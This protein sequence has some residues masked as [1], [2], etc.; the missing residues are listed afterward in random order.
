M[1]Y[2][3]GLLLLSTLLLAGCDRRVPNPGEYYVEN[4]NQLLATGS[5]L[6][7]AL[8]L[9]VHQATGI[10]STLNGQ[11]LKF[12]FRLGQYYTIHSKHALGGVLAQGRYRYSLDHDNISRSTLYL[13]SHDGL[14]IY[15]DFS[16]RKAGR[17]VAQCSGQD[18]GRFSGTFSTVVNR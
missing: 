6:G 17:Y 14:K 15:L 13:P 4:T 9:R 18:T 16:S 1:R 2:I 5:M 10:Y 3:I 11:K 12:E 7:N 8:Y